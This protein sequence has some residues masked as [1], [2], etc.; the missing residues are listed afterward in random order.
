MVVFIDFTACD[1][2]VTTISCPWR[3]VLMFSLILAS[4]LAQRTMPTKS[5][6][7]SGFFVLLEHPKNR[8]SQK[9]SKA[10]KRQ[11]QDSNS[12]KTQFNRISGA[13]M[14]KSAPF[15][16]IKRPG[17]FWILYSKRLRPFFI[18]QEVSQILKTIRVRIRSPTKL[19]GRT[20]VTI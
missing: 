13:E 15:F 16:I 6:I 19:H 18:L 2:C 12:R 20:N 8:C 11:N 1:L 3:M 17:S 7:K 10:E 4:G 9:M 14:K 5:P